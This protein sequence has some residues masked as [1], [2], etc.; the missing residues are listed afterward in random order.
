VVECRS[1]K[2]DRNEGYDGQWEEWKRLKEKKQDR[3]LGRQQHPTP[4]S[5]GCL[6][7]FFLSLPFEHHNYSQCF[8]IIQKN[9]I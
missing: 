4:C 3:L 9:Y 5:H 7:H 6:V 2:V 1:G 8:I